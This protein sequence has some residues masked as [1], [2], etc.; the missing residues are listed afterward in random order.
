MQCKGRKRPAENKSAVA[1]FEL[2]SPHQRNSLSRTI[3]VHKLMETTPEESYLS[4]CLSIES[5]M[6]GFSGDILYAL[7][8]L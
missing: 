7:S 3:C 4:P 6:G 8:H 1:K 5:R 2:L